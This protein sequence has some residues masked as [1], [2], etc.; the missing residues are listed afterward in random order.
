[1]KR[2]Q[3]IDSITRGAAWTLVGGIW[4]RAHG[5]AGPA[6]P[7]GGFRQVH[8][9][10]AVGGGSCPADGSPSEGPAA[11]IEVYR[12]GSNTDNI[13]HGQNEWNDGGVA[14]SICKIAFEVTFIEGDVSGK[15]YFARIYT[16]TGTA[17]NAL[18]ASSNGLTGISTTGW[19]VL[20][21]ASPFATGG[22]STPYGLAIEAPSADGTNYLW[23]SNSTSAEIAGHRELWN[24][25]GVAQ[26]GSGDDSGLRIYWQ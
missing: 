24:A 6:G 15:T 10:A 9:A 1:M 19:K 17:L 21:F 4:V 2:R 16:L 8:A 3:F 12:F 14:R 13:F 22:S 20:T 11:T 18:Q 5:A 7:S 26:V 23:V 25:G